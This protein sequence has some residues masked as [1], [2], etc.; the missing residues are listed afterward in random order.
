MNNGNNVLLYDMFYKD[1]SIAPS[2]ISLPE[3][4]NLEFDKLE[5]SVLKWEMNGNVTYYIACVVS[6][7][8]AHGSDAGVSLR[9]VL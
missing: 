6:I 9:D 2:I 1:V 8:K 3:V 5:D 4:L 7:R